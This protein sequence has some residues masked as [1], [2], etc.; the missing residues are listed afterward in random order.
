VERPTAR[1]VRVSALSEEEVRS[2]MLSM[3]FEKFE[4]RRYLRYDRADLAFIR[5]APGLWRQLKPKD[6]ASI[7]QMCEEAITA[8]YEQLA[9]K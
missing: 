3:P 1:T 4:R 9:S 2:V 8:Y 6:L 7:R 5:F